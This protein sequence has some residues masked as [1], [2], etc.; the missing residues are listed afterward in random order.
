VNERTRSQPEV[1]ELG[2]LY[3]RSPISVDIGWKFGDGYSP[4][5][6]ISSSICVQGFAHLIGHEVNARRPGD[7]PRNSTDDHQ[8]G[9]Q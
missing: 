5:L 4:V 6:L 7:R 3:D 8:G 2:L 1:H 9:M